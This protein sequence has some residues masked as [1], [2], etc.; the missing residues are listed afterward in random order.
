MPAE[1][2]GTLFTPLEQCTSMAGKFVTLEEAARLLGLSTDEL[3]DMRSRGELRGFR[4]GTSWKFPDAEI[5]RLL[6]ERG[7]NVLDDGVQPGGSS[8]LVGE[9]GKRSPGGSGSSVVG[10]SDV[11]LIPGKQGGSDVAL[12]SGGRGADSIRRVEDK[13]PSVGG[14]QGAK[15]GDE[16]SD[17]DELRVSD[18]LSDDFMLDAPPAGKLNLPP[19]EGS[20]VLGGLENQL[21]GS[22]SGGT[23]DLVRGDS[24]PSIDPDDDLQIS[25]EDESDDL[26]LAPSSDVSVTGDSGINLMSPSDSGLSLEAEPLDLAGSS[27]SALD[28]GIEGPG[29]GATPRSGRGS[30]AKSGP[31]SGSKSGSGSLA[32]FQA[33]E[34]FQLAPSGSG[35]DFDEDS[36]GSQVIEV[37]DSSAAMPDLVDFGADALEEVTGGLS[38]DPLGMDAGM[39]M[40]GAALAPAGA[41]AYET[42]Y[43]VWNLLSLAGILAVLSLAGMLMTDL[44]RNMFGYSETPAVTTSVTNALISMLGLGK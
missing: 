34:D 18:D 38:E 26:V 24:D 31:R 28:L 35:L 1:I 33:D 20:D 11:A 4:D 2:A 22:G 16:D 42:P 25:A 10:G 5:D 44:V 32:E 36:S 37:E 12:V 17:D 8:I 9:P 43:S 29:S 19:S 14:K 6:A 30:G 41:I 21:Q 13:L 15:P 23:G 39:G 7:V 40:A 3:V 27:I